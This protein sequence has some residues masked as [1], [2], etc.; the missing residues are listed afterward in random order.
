MTDL[1]ESLTIGNALAL[2][3]G[4]YLF[5]MGVGLPFFPK[6]MRGKV[7]VT[8]IAII[9][10]L[11][12]GA[13]LMMRASMPASPAEM[14]LMEIRNEIKPPRQIDDM[15]RIDDVTS[16]GNK[17]IYHITLTTNDPHTLADSMTG[18]LKN[19]VCQNQDFLQL[20]LGIT[21]EVR[22]KDATGNTLEPFLI[23][24]SDCGQPA[25]PT[26]R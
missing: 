8:I 4:L 22:F 10:L 2:A 24:P 13:N 17:V 3:A 18:D 11:S 16:E 15:I 25:T 14:V 26:R 1:F 7:W 19:D 21:V 6:F 23:R 5:L 12:A 9:V 20:G